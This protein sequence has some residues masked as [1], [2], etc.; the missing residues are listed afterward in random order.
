M[1]ISDT[2]PEKK[3]GRTL[4]AL[5]LIGVAIFFY[6]ERAVVWTQL[7]E[8][9]LIPRPERFTEL[10]LENHANLP[11]F[12]SAGQT[13]PFSFTVHNLEGQAMEYSYRVYA[14]FSDNGEQQAIG[15]GDLSLEQNGVKTIENVFTF[16][17]NQK[18]V[19]IFMT[20]PALGQE[21]HFILSSS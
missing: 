14:V 5:L 18:K 4:A 1:H 21:I 10:Y 11:K 16:P 7:D 12:V 19:T 2:L 20:L 9:K 3:T 17:E 8:W 13:V 6:I 15:Q